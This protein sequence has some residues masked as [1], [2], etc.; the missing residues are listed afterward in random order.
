M[1]LFRSKTM[2]LRTTNMCF[3]VPLT[4]LSFLPVH[5]MTVAARSRSPEPAPSIFLALL[6]A[7]G[8]RQDKDLLWL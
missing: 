8:T 1:D 7:P 5:R 6:L 4:I 2:T 3:Q